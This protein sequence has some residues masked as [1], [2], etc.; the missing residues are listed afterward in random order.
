MSI[1]FRSDVFTIIDSEAEDVD[2][3]VFEETASESASDMS[4]V[5]GAPVYPVRGCCG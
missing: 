5:H 4:L 3:V 2:S 1:M